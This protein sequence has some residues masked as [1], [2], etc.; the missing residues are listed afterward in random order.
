MNNSL[1]VLLAAVFTFAVPLSCSADIAV[2]V[3][4]SSGIESISKSDV[5]GIFLGRMTHLAGQPVKPL[6]RSLNLPESELFFR[7]ISGLSLEGLQRYWV[8]AHAR[9]VARKPPTVSFSDEKLMEVV[10]TLP[11]G[12]SYI[13]ASAVNSSVRVVFVIGELG[14]LELAA[15]K[16]CTAC[17]QTLGP[18]YKDIALRYTAADL[19]YLT[20]KVLE[21]GVGVW[22]AIPMPPN[23]AL[24]LSQLEAERIVQWILS[25]K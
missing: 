17:H 23:K 1:L 20:S 14:P 5:E 4:P 2:I 6:L 11:G 22:G 9:G 13:D 21:G 16:G 7:T 3:N 25:A 8:D 12:M 24:G 18:S 19:S 10:A 15:N